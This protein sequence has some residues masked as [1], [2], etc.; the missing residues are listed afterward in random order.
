[1][2]LKLSVFGQLACLYMMFKNVESNVW[3]L[4]AAILGVCFCFMLCCLDEDD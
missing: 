3:T 1:M 2:K 4:W